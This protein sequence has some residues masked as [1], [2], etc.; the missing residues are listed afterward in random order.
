MGLATVCLVTVSPLFGVL[1]RQNYDSFRVTVPWWPDRVHCT[2][3]RV[4][5]AAPLTRAL[6]G[7]GRE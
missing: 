1:A 3:L 2:F 7:G 6:Q 4:Y 5:S